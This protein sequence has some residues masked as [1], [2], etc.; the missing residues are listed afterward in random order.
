[1]EWVYLLGNHDCNL[2]M[3]QVLSEFMAECPRFQWQA[4]WWQCGEHLFLHGDLLDSEGFEGHA[5]Y[6]KRYLQPRST[7][8]WAQRSFAFVVETRFHWIVPWMIHR[9]RKTCGR[10]ARYLATQASSLLPYRHVYFG[11]THVPINGMLVGEV[12]YSNPGS[13]IR[14]LPFRPIRFD[15]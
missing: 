15:F 7:T 6:R 2:E 9:P 1:M 8:A 5:E 12:R 11:H 13:G 4:H 14:H 10:M 3:Q